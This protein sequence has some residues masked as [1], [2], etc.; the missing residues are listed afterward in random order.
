M[1]D[2]DLDDL[3]DAWIVQAAIK[4]PA[5]STQQPTTL[6]H[7]AY[8]HKARSK[9]VEEYS[10]SWHS[11]FLTPRTSSSS[12]NA[13]IVQRAWAICGFMKALEMVFTIGGALH[14]RYVVLYPPGVSAC[15]Y[16]RSVRTSNAI[17]QSTTRKHTCTTTPDGSLFECW[18]VVRILAHSQSFFCFLAPCCSSHPQSRP[19]QRLDALTAS[20]MHVSPH[21][22]RAR[23]EIVSV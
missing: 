8:V 19:R 22:A 12:S 14:R 23:G 21:L 13:Q 4:W 2:F 17:E 5:L 10:P 11:C 1:F 15:S 6:G 16:F 18:H 9:C 3:D 7:C 20:T